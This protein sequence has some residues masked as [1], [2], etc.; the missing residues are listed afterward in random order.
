MRT[1]SACWLIV[2]ALLCSSAAS[3]AAPNILIMTVDN[4]GYGDLAAYSPDSPIKTPRIDRLA[5][6][7]ARLTN[8]YTASSTCTVSRACLLTG[9][10]AQRHGLENQLP[11][12]AGNYG[13]GLDQREQ[14]I[15]RYLK[16]APTP[17]A[18]G[19]FGKWNI[20]FAP[21]SRPIERGFDEFIGHVS[22]NMDY[23]RH[24]YRDRHDLYEGIEPL[25]REGTYATDLFADAAIDF[26]QRRSAEDAPWFVYLPFN[27]PHFPSA[28]NRREGEPNDWQAPDWALAE[29]GLAPEEK[30]QTKRFHA[31]MTALDRGIGRVLDALDDAGVAEE[32][33]VF[34]MS[35]N[36]AFTQ[37]GREGI[38]VGT[39]SPL[40]DGGITCWEGGIRVPAFARW[41]G[42]IEPGSVIDEVCWSPDLLVTAAKLAY[43]PLPDDVV[44]DGKDILPLLTEGADSPHESLYFEFRS[45]AA[46]RQGDWKIVRE[47]PTQEWMLFNLAED[48]GE[49]HDLAN[50]HPERVQQLATE[51]ERWQQEIAQSREPKTYLEFIRT[52]A[53]RLRADDEPP[54]TLADSRQQNTRLGEHLLKAWGGFPDES[55]S[56]EPRILDTLQRDGYRVEKVIF[57]TFPGVWMTANAYVPEGE[58]K[59]PAVLCVHGHWRGAKQDPNVQARCVGL[60]K[61]GFF[62]LAVDAFGAGERGVGKALGEYHGDMTAAT[63]LPIGRPLSGLQV[64]ENMRAVD[65]LL[66]RDEVDGERLGVTGASGGGNQTMYAGA[67]D[68]RFKAAV[69]VCSVGNYQ[70]YLGAAC[71]MCEVVPG[72]LRFTEEWGVLALT[73]P[74]ALMVINASQ[75]ARQFSIEEAQ[76]SLEKTDD[77]FALHG[78]PDHLRHTT[79]D[80]PHAYNQPMREAMYGWMTLHLKGEGDGSPIAE[81]EMT[82]EEPEA[83]RCYPGESRPDDWLTLPQFAARE[84]RELLQGRSA[85]SSRDELEQQTKQLRRRLDEGLGGTT[86][87]TKV[88]S[89]SLKSPRTL[90]F[91]PEENVQLTATVVDG[92]GETAAERVL[93]ISCDGTDT[94]AVQ[95]YVEAALISGRTA[96]TLGLRATGEQAVERNRVG[97]APDHN[98]AEWSLWI[99][100]PLLGQWVQDVRAAL[101]ALEATAGEESDTGEV[102]LVGIGPAGVVALCVGAIDERIDHVVAAGSLASYLSDV[103]YENQR[104]GLMAP[105][106]VRDVGDIPHIAALLAPSGTRLTIAGGVTGGGETLDASQLDEQ[107]AAARGAF[108]VCGSAERL[109]ILPT[110]SAAELLNLP[111]G[112]ER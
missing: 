88:I 48:I 11:G 84:G 28:G 17:Y 83:L 54:T 58:G 60:A 1:V 13:V 104:L 46:L 106:I 101:D 52:E 68:E 35:D 30:D 97:R 51:F 89:D 63:L 74:R 75:D 105:G 55:A 79:F 111:E 82:L 87:D 37:L 5:G 47:K 25:H 99:G 42:R 32:T 80:S 18:T 19:C 40:H 12:V 100:R 102:T 23:Y 31:N 41:P 10:V 49:Q 62:V 72:A 103:P 57:Q 95:E 107:Y 38:D 56:L 98:T 66:T 36:G 61:L 71:C 93:V 27:A 69:P 76:K 77:V 64:Y 91:A 78:K 67:W 86:P 81:P 22:G 21:G 110:G 15:P 34:L 112:I 53:A 45:H 26:I 65:Y 73:A 85:P 7:G 9:R 3:A 4:V 8:F 44:L 20:G 39:N 6:E 33:F 90:E 50:E 24:N 2:L 92:K 94:P 108:E 96:I 43:A 16:Q 109:R 70:A 14:L 59:R 29:Y